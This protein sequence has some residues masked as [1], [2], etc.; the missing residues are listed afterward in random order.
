VYLLRVSDMQ[1]TM[2]VMCPAL[3]WNNFLAEQGLHQGDHV[4]LTLYRLMRSCQEFDLVVE[5]RVVRKYQGV[6]GLLRGMLVLPLYLGASH[7]RAMRRA[8]WM[9]LCLGLLCICVGA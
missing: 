6:G 5:E 9:I 7:M 1:G 8:V 2:I 4:L 3:K